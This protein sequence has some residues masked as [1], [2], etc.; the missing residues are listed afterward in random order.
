MIKQWFI[1]SLSFISILGTSCTGGKITEVTGT[2]GSI[3]ITPGEKLTIDLADVVSMNMENYTVSL[4]AFNDDFTTGKT[5]YDLTDLIAAAG[6]PTE[7][8]F[9]IPKSVV[10]AR[11]FAVVV[12]IPELTTQLVD[13]VYGGDQ[14]SKPGL[15]STLTFNLLRNY[16][17]KKPS[18]YVS[19]DYHGIQDLIQIRMEQL[20][21]DSDFLSYS[22]TPYK[23]LMRYFTNG[24]AFNLE[25]LESIKTFHVVYGF[26][27]A[28]VPGINVNDTPEKSL[29]HYQ[30]AVNFTIDGRE[31]QNPPF[32]HSNVPPMLMQGA[33]LPNPGTNLV[34]IE[35]RKVSVVTQGYDNDEDYIDKNMIVEYIPRVLPKVLTSV[36]GFPFI[37]EPVS[38]YLTMN[39]LSDVSGIDT[40][41]SSTIAR[42]EALDL[43]VFSTS[44]DFDPVLYPKAT[45]TDTAYRN[46][47]YLIS[48]GMVRIPFRW[49]FKY[50]DG[51]RDPVIV[52]D[53]NGKMNDSSI[54]SVITKKPDGTSETEMY[55]GTGWLQHG[56]HC[57]SDATKKYQYPD[58][59]DPSI[60]LYVYYQVVKSKA[61]SPWNCVFRVTDPDI[62]E[63]P[64]GAADSFYYSVQMNDPFTTVRFGI[65]TVKKLWPIYTPAPNNKPPYV[66]GSYVGPG[67]VTP[68]GVTHPRCGRARFQVTIDNS[69]KNAA[70]AKA[71]MLYSY[72]V[73]I[74]DRKPEVSDPTIPNGR[75]TSTSISRTIQILPQPARLVNFSAPT[76]ATGA[77]GL[78]ELYVATNTYKRTDTYLSEL[79]ALAASQNSLGSDFS[80]LGI[81]S[82]I[83]SSPLI[84]SAIRSNFFTGTAQEMSPYVTQ[85]FSIT[86]STVTLDAVTK[87][88]T[89]ATHGN[90]QLL[91]N[92]LTA[93]SSTIYS[94][95]HEYD[96]TCN[97]PTNNMERA[98]D[99][100][101]L[102]SNNL[103]WD[104]ETPK[105][106][107]FEID[108]IDYD[109][110]G[111][112]VGEV[113]DPVK[114]E[115]SHDVATNLNSNG[116]QFCT[117]PAPNT[118]P[119]YY[120]T[121]L[122]TAT[123][124][125]INSDTCTWSGTAPTYMQ[126][127][128]VYYSYSDNGISTVKKWV[129]H[130]LR[131]KWQ[132]KDQGLTN[133]K[134]IADP[135]G[136]I[137]N[138]IKAG[139]K[140]QG[141]RWTMSSEVMD[142]NIITDPI[143]L[144]A[145]RKDMKPCLS[146]LNGQVD[147]IH[148]M[149]TSI[150][151]RVQFQVKDENKVLSSLPT[152]PVDSGALMGRFEAEL[153]LLGTR[154]I[155]DAE[156]LKF[157]PYSLNCSNGDQKSSVEINNNSEFAFPRLDPQNKII[158]PASVNYNEPLIWYSTVNNI[159]RIRF[160]SAT[161]KNTFCMNFNYS[162]ISIQPSLSPAL[163][164]VNEVILIQNLSATSFLLTNNFLKTC[165]ARDSLTMNPDQKYIA[166]ASICGGSHHLLE[167]VWG[168]SK[169]A[170]IVKFILDPTTANNGGYPAGTSLNLDMFPSMYQA[171]AL[172]KDTI[173][174]FPALFD[175]PNGLFFE[176]D[177]FD[178][179]YLDDVLKIPVYSGYKDN[180]NHAIWLPNISGNSYNVLASTLDENILLP[181]PTD[182][183]PNPTPAPIPSSTPDFSYSLQV[184]DWDTQPLFMA[185]ATPTPDAASSDVFFRMTPG[186]SN[187]IQVY[188]KNNK[189]VS[190][191]IQVRD[192]LTG[193]ESDPFD[194][195]Q[196]G[197]VAP[198][199]PAAIPTSTPSFT[200]VGRTSCLDAPVNYPG[201]LSTLNVSA[202]ANFKIC[203]F[204]WTPDVLDNGKQAFNYSFEVQDNYY[205]S[206]VPG[207]TPNPTP[208]MGVG[209]KHPA[210]S[211]TS[212]IISDGLIK[213]N[214]PSLTNFYIDLVAIETNKAP[215]FT[216][217]SGS[218][219][220]NLYIPAGGG[221]G[222]TTAFPGGGVQPGCAGSQSSSY[223]DTTKVYT[224]ATFSPTPV[225]FSCG[226][227]VASGDTLQS[228]TPNLMQEGA[229]FKFTVNAKDENVT[230][231]LRTIT[232]PNK[233]TQVLIIDGPHAGRTFTVP[234][235]SNMTITPSGPTKGTAT[236]TFNWTPTDSEANFLS[237]S[238]G[239][240]IPITITD[241]DYSPSTDSTFPAAFKVSKIP[242]TV[243]IWAKLSVKNTAPVAYY[244][245]GNSEVLLS[246][247]TLPLQA[248]QTSVITIRIKDPDIARWYQSGDQ[249]G[250]NLSFLDF[251]SPS[252]ITVGVVGP[253]KLSSDYKYIIQD[254]TIT[255]TPSVSNL[256]LD[257]SPSIIITDPGDPSLGLAL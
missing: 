87:D 21:S 219:I 174:T 206:W 43:G 37:P 213:S 146:G 151:N 2:N 189:T 27:P 9:T 46:V 4:R 18:D 247:T 237:N 10:G 225:T 39:E 229:L 115:F 13:A 113:S 60:L 173:N 111:L 127:I 201:T 34:V 105:G 186:D 195:M 136:Y 150:T 254:I 71:D 132:P 121:Y 192:V 243:W 208:V 220:D 114:I 96:S 203:N 198:V 145:K 153:K 58:P 138:M 95:P 122:A 100:S 99:G 68:D 79:V 170:A 85:P 128:P 20:I 137:Q 175:K 143:K 117:Y 64:N 171:D 118:D 116:I 248:G 197:L 57:E 53:E 103:N 36:T 172:K 17:G 212:G 256:G 125:A 28:P 84:T 231:E 82:G 158:P 109:N 62:D 154:N 159:P 190:F 76:P 12:D 245:I 78:S 63:D 239:F 180:Q 168:D 16:Q 73:S 157:I 234:S 185:I 199:A 15:A 207:P 161:D 81:G 211:S 80:L 147:T 236:F 108:A 45:S 5:L 97:L 104:Q 51:N 182:L 131:V 252:Y 181:A 148:Q 74:Y 167:S 215:Y 250:F 77:V 169:S 188:V 61:D 31:A 23:K 101:G 149:N 126:A 222:W 141:Q 42:N 196:F 249:S 89:A 194:I 93:A 30:Y 200:G 22:T 91:G 94:F 59:S 163:T 160:Q 226:L 139:F 242:N 6:N 224:P 176:A 217:G 130:R 66:E 90:L 251:A 123:K 32:N 35:G 120:Q 164:P 14:K 124:A 3:K 49:N 244:L 193:V 129:Y 142:Q 69:L 255:A 44:L 54:D 184:V 221:S 47:Y 33:S 41:T 177:I 29:D 135:A 238:G 205:S 246:G 19:A 7:F 253:T 8:S 156:F 216:N 55:P 241:Q 144:F 83:N 25:F 72:N 40:Y 98:K 230:D 50:A 67:C 140:T 204:T 52:R 218:K 214:G 1:L 179:F 240:L 233:P 235:F 191:P 152:A 178:T 119:A 183:K 86:G 223:I 75:S 24:L 106:W 257:S 107:V 134:T 26:D 70:E 155:T 110:V 56:S 227:S 38:E 232:I 162:P 133:G 210:G 165:T 209:G 112:A 65:D 92:M 166:I 102:W 187:R 202:L 228:A 88:G 11:P 48:D